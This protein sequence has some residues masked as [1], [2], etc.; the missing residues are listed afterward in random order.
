MQKETIRQKDEASRIAA[1]IAHHP[2]AGIA[3]NPTMLM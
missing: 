2:I 1:T 3:H